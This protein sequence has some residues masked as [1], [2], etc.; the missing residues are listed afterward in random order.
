MSKMYLTLFY[1]DTDLFYC[2]KCGIFTLE[3]KNKALRKVKNICFWCN[4]KHPL[5]VTCGVNL[6]M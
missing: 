1:S 2:C 5:V 6:P 4:S 3:Y